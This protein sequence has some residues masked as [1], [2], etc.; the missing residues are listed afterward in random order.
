MLLISSTIVFICSMYLSSVWSF[1]Q[2]LHHFLLILLLLYQYLHVLI[3]VFYKTAKGLLHTVY[4]PLV[5]II[6]NI[7]FLLDLFCL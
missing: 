4:D 1:P 5:R 3:S 7:Y 6:D 2:H